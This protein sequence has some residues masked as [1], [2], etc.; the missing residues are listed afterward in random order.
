MGRLK[1]IQGEMKMNGITKK[2]KQTFMYKK[3]YVPMKVKCVKKEIEKDAAAY[4]KNTYEKVMGRS[5]HL[6]PPVT[7]TEKIQW[8][9]LYDDNPLYTLC[10]DKVAVREYITKNFLGGGG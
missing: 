5:L 8:Q 10:A 3:I 4:I 9:K 6:D 7:Y 1:E 2:L